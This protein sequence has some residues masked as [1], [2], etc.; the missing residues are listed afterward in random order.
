M[1]M[2][3]KLDADLSGKLIDQ[4][5]YCSKIGSLMYLTSSRPDIV[6][7]VCYCARI[8]R[9]IQFLG[10]KLVSWMSKKKDCTAMSSG[11]VEYVAL[12]AS[13]AQVKNDIIELYLVRTEYQL[14]DIFTKALPEDK[15]QYLVRRIVMKE[16]P[17]RVNIKQLCGSLI[18]AESDSLPHAHAQTTKTYYWHRDS[19]IKKAQVHTK[20]KTSANSEIQDLPLRFQV[21]QGRL[22]AS[23]QD[24]AKHEHVGQD[25]RSKNGK[26]DKDKQ[27]KDLKI[28]KS[29][30]KL[31]DNNKG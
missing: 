23:F 10:D 17:S 16:N 21:Y 26:D 28:L 27:G 12:F 7:E 1:A 3:P 13:C 29:K 22:L 6:Q 11:K 8:S 25:T 15:F 20:T 14:A 31:K 4:I 24:D 18:P 2:K 19:R 9:G 30:T 5:D